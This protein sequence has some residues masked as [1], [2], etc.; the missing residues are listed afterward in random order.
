M[1]TPWYLLHRSTILPCA[2]E[3]NIVQYVLLNFVNQKHFHA[4]TIVLSFA[5]TMVWSDHSVFKINLFGL[6]RIG[7][8]KQTRRG[9]RHNCPLLHVELLFCLPVTHWK[10]NVRTLWLFPAVSSLDFFFYFVF[11]LFDINLVFSFLQNYLVVCY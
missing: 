8:F 7:Y 9:W 3:Q 4:H 6:K 10:I 2:R 5:K 1:V 11:I